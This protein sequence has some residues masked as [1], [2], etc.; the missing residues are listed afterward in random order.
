MRGYDEYAASG[1]EGLLVTQEFRSP[2]LKPLHDWIGAKI[3]DQLQFD[4][5]WDFAYLRDQKV[6]VGAKH[7]AAID[8]A[9]LGFQYAVGR[10]F[11]ARFDYG[12]QLQSAPGAAHT[13]KQIDVAVVLNN[14][15][16]RFEENWIGWRTTLSA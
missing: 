11:S 8:S 2:A 4:A 9:G 7:G 6:L 10:Y 12:W 16:Q 5:F 14:W 15:R 13:G 3:D 1:S